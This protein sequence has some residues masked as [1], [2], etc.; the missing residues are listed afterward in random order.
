MEAEQRS[1]RIPGFRQKTTVKEVNLLVIIL[2][3]Q[4]VKLANRFNV[5][6]RD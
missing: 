6:G 4:F 2:D 5:R 1:G 3:V